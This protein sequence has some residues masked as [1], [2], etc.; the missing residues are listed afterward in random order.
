MN[1]IVI[2]TIPVDDN[3]LRLGAGISLILVGIAIIITTGAI[4]FTKKG[5]KIASYCFDFDFIA[6]Q[7]RAIK[8][9]DQLLSVNYTMQME[10]WPEIGEEIASIRG[11]INYSWNIEQVTKYI[12]AR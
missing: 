1:E 5:E 10:S 11:G 8:L 6:R 2:R 9:L 12:D 3:Y 4:V 7:Q